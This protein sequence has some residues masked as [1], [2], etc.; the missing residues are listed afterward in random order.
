MP[1]DLGLIIRWR[2]DS[3]YFSN[4]QIGPPD[5]IH[6]LDAGFATFRRGEPGGA[7]LG[8]GRNLDLENRKVLLR[9]SRHDLNG[10]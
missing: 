7:D 3:P 1:P 8:A 9:V 5:G 2:R 10:V 4:I 6:R